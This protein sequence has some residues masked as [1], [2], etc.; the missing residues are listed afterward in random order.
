MTNTDTIITPADLNRVAVLIKTIPTRTLASNNRVLTMWSDAPE[1]TAK[2][3]SIVLKSGALP[4]QWSVA[5]RTLDL[6]VNDGA[7]YCMVR[8]QKP[9]SGKE[10]PA[11]RELLTAA[12][13]KWINYVDPILERAQQIRAEAVQAQADALALM[14]PT[15]AVHPTAWRVVGQDI[16]VTEVRTLTYGT[17]EHSAFLRRVLPECGT[18]RA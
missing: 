9:G 13:V 1:T 7:F 6:K 10:W 18:V 15:S 8:G 16:E 4:Y 14:A 2:I 11:L 17:P 3:V 12:K 5:L